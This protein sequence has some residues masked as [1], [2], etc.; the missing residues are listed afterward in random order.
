MCD[1]VRLL[2]SVVALLLIVVAYL[3]GANATLAYRL[4]HEAPGWERAY[5]HDRIMS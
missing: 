3:V 1:A 4:F 2:E 5:D